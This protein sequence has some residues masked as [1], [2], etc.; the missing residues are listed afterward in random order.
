MTVRRAGLAALALLAVI[1]G[2]NLYSA[3]SGFVTAYDTYDRLEMRLARFNYTNPNAPIDIGFEI[4]NP[5]GETVQVTTIEVFVDAGVHRVGGGTLTPR[6]RFEP[7][8]REIF[9]IDGNI[10]DTDYVTRLNGQQITWGV[11]G[12]VLVQ[13]HAGLDPVWIPFAGSYVSE[14]GS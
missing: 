2:Y 14:P 8:Y 4:A 6:Q 1:F 13:L 7:N 12:R 11:S 10:D 9:A 3:A 5:T